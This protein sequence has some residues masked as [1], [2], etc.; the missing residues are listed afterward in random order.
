MGPFKVISYYTNNGYEKEAQKLKESMEFFGLDFEIVE[1]EDRG[2]WMANTNYK[3]HFVH[4]MMEK[5]PKTPLVYT[6]VDSVF[7]KYPEL[8]EKLEC[9]FACHFRVGQELLSGTMY[10]QDEDLTNQLIMEWKYEVARFPSTWEQKNLHQALKRIQNKHPLRFQ[11]LP[12]SYC[13]IFDIMRDE[14]EPVIEHYQASRRL[15]NVNC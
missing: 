15:K 2:S 8:F 13:Q 11:S 3:P 6:D 10:F 9:D 5:F 14:G 4:D 1:V 12:A 7:L